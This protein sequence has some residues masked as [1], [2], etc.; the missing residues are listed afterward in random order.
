MASEAHLRKR[1]E[2]SILLLVMAI[3]ILMFDIHFIFRN[4]VVMVKTNKNVYLTFKR[5]YPQRA[6]AA[7]INDTGKL[8]LI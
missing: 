1:C 8:T 6:Q 5:S 2:T 3:P 7:A 4:Q